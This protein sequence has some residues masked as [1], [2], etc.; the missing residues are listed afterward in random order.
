MNAGTLG[1]EETIRPIMCSARLYGFIWSEWE[2][3]EH[4]ESREYRGVAYFE[5][6]IMRT[7]T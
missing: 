3:M 6:K 2:Q 5:D 4:N 1:I 7:I